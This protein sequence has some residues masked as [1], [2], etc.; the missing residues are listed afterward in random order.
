MQETVTNAGALTTAEFF[1]RVR[2]RLTLDVPAAL[3]DPSLT[4]TRGDHDADPVMKKI[5]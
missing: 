4:P 3:S 2:A 5:A 1:A